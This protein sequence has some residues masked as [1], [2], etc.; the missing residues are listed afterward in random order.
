MRERTGGQ[1][2][3]TYNQAESIIIIQYGILTMFVFTKKVVHTRR[4]ISIACITFLPMFIS[5]Q[6][7]FWFPQF[8]HSSKDK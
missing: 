2:K 8:P 1:L 3:K 4:K 5:F 7:S 6:N